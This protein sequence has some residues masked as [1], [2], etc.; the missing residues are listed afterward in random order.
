M[1]YLKGAILGMIVA[2]VFWIPDILTWLGALKAG[3][4]GWVAP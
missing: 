1:D 2:L 3:F 4:A